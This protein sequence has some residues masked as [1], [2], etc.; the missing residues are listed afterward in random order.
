MNVHYIYTWQTFFWRSSKSK[1]TPICENIGF[2]CS[3]VNLINFFP[4]IFWSNYNIWTCMYI[5]VHSYIH[6]YM[7]KY[8]HIYIHTCIHALTCIHTYIICLLAH[9]HYSNGF[10]H[11]HYY[12]IVAPS[13]LSFIGS[14]GMEV[15]RSLLKSQRDCIHT[16]W[17][18]VILKLWFFHSFCIVQDKLSSIIQIIT[19]KNHE[20][21]NVTSHSLFTCA[22][23]FNLK[24]Y[25]SP[26]CP[27]LL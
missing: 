25:C 23:I 27:L 8:T 7:Y 16:L 24:D 5:Y 1:T 14:I 2:K 9:V 21:K 17:K 26:A 12:I 13:N 11:K 19:W 22:I 4:L 20:F 15:Y 6:K 10:M 18:Y 3:S